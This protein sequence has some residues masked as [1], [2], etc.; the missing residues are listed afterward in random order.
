MNDRQPAEGSRASSMRRMV[1]IATAVA[2]AVAIVPEFFH[3]YT[4]YFGFDG[5]PWFHAWSAAGT[6]IALV[7]VARILGAILRRD[8]DHYDR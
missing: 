5:L 2:V 7:I 4:G 3:A 8:E 6:A 1:L